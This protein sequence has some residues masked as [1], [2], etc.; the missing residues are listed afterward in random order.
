MSNED[1]LARIMTSPVKTINANDTLGSAAEAMVMNEIGAVVV[2]E[3]TNLIGIVTERDIVKQ[4]V[5]TSDVLKKPVKQLLVKSLITAEP[6]TTIQEAF[7]TMLKNKIRRLPV[8]D[9]SKLV[10]MVTEKDLM[11]WV[12]RVCYEPN[13]PP[14]IKAVLDPC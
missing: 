1:T 10:G 4:V 7:A 8:V 3:G 11:R 2:I 5:G 14:H 9:D 12:L 6:G 13:I